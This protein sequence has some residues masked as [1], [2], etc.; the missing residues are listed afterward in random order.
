MY[1][2]PYYMIAWMMTCLSDV[3]FLVRLVVDSWS[4]W[5]AQLE[6]DLGSG[7]FRHPDQ[8]QEDGMNSGWTVQRLLWL[9]HLLMLLV[10][11]A[12]PR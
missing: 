12:A 7:P 11:E 5:E 10:L 9:Q 2:Q 4:F 6:L 1:S 3:F 8:A